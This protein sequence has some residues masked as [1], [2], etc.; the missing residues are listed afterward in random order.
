MSKTIIR[1][2]LATPA[3]ADITKHPQVIVKMDEAYANSR[4][5]SAFFGKEHLN[6]LKAIDFLIAEDTEW[7]VVSFNETYIVNKQN[8]MSYRE[9]DITKDG[10]TELVMGFT[11]SQARQFKRAYIKRFNEMEAHIKSVPRNVT[12]QLLSNPQALLDA[13]SGASQKVITLEAERDGLGETV[14]F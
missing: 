9:Y 1:M 10:F 3:T 4:D 7:G 11:G 13:L 12:T 8:G 14:A 6:V 5:I 2:D